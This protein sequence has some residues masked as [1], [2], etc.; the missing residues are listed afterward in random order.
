MQFNTDSQGFYIEYDQCQWE[1]GNLR[2][3]YNRRARDIIALG[4]KLILGISSGVDSQAALRSFMDQGIKIET[5]FL[6]MPGYNDIE[7]NNLK[8]LTIRI[9]YHL[10]YLF[11]N[12]SKIRMPN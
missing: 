12:D 6:Y 4:D 7:F 11:V 8:K 10:S 9:F 5:A 2:E 3:E 1:V